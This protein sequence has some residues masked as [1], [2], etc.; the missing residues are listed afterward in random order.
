MP[1]KGKTMRKRKPKLN[2][3]LA[4]AWMAILTVLALGIVC[5]VLIAI[6]AVCVGYIGGLG[7]IIFNLMQATGMH[8]Q[9]A[10]VGAVLTVV[11]IFI[12]GYKI[13]QWAEP[14]ADD[15]WK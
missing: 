15:A 4:M 11:I 7:L 1:K 6:L 3:I 5:S 9:A 10:A 2:T 13:T 14:L 8:Y 12:G